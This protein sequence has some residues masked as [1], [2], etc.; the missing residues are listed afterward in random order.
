MRK[1]TVAKTS[2]TLIE[3]L[4]VIAI[5]AI[6]ASMLLP[7]LGKARATAYKSGCASNMKQIHYGMSMYYNDYRNN[8]AQGSDYYGTDTSWI[9]LNYNA[10]LPFLTSFDQK[11]KGLHPYSNAGTSRLYALDYITVPKALVCP[12]AA[13]VVSEQILVSKSNM[14]AGYHYR[15]NPKNQIYINKAQDPYT[16]S[17][18][19]WGEFNRPSPVATYPAASTIK[20]NWRRVMLSDF[21]M[22]YGYNAAYAGYASHKGEGYNLLAFSGSIKWMPDSKKAVLQMPGTT[23]IRDL[24]GGNARIFSLFD[25]FIAK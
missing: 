1:S 15:I 14:L 7:A 4:V 20:D 3:L 23:G 16:S 9:D 18:F 13:P 2:F 22:D 12:S 24:T 8:W 25:N 5:I 11:H 6:L 21:F 19:G 17:D 10:K